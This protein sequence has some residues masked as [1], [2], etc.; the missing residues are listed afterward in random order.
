MDIRKRTGHVVAA[1]VAKVSCLTRVGTRARLE[2]VQYKWH[3]ASQHPAAITY[4]FYG[5]G[6]LLLSVCYLSVVNHKL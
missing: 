2:T 5:H 3:T 1:G 4:S 6:L